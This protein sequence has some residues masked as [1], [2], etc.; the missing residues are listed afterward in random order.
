MSLW[1]SDWFKRDKLCI[2]LGSDLPHRQVA[3]DLNIGLQ[4]LG[5]RSRLFSMKRRFSHVH[6]YAY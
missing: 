6:V 4:R 5:N 1:Q 2:A 3:S